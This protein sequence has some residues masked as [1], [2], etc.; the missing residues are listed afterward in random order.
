LL[1]IILKELVGA[2]SIRVLKDAPAQGTG[3]AHFVTKSVSY[4]QAMMGEDTNSAYTKSAYGMSS[5]SNSS[6]E[7]RKPHAREC[8]KSQRSKL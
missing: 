5:N 1:Q 2:D 3:T 7:E 4:L 6:K 8:K